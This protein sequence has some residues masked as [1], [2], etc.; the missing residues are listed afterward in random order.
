MENTLRRLNIKLEESKQPT[1]NEKSVDNI[2]EGKKNS[3]VD[4]NEENILSELQEA[5]KSNSLLENKIVALQEKLSACYTR[6]S[7]Q[8]DEIET[9]KKAIS[10]LSKSANRV[11]TLEEKLKIV[12]NRLNETNNLV[13]D[14]ESKISNLTEKLN[15]SISIKNSL[16]ESVNRTND[17]IQILTERYNSEIDKREFEIQKLSEDLAELQKDSKLKQS[18]YRSKLEKANKL[19]EKYKNIAN[20]AVDRY[21]ESQAVKLGVNSNEIKNKLPSSYTFNDIDT[22]CEDL[23]EYKLSMNKL[24]FRNLTENFNMKVTSPKQELPI[25]AGNFDDDIDEGLMSLAGLNK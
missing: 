16:K 5:L 19:V 23:Q 9:Y 17:K 24:P 3:S 15:S 21:I 18:D 8:E 11:S 25:P 13:K 12:S 4:N 20:K 6:E 7:K 2:D 14:R 10:K 22:I 1:D